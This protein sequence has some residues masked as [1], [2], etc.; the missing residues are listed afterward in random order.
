[1]NPTRLGAVTFAVPLG[2]LIGLAAACA[3]HHCLDGQSPE[4]S[5]GGTLADQSAGDSAVSP[6][7]SAECGTRSMARPK[8]PTQGINTVPIRFAAKTESASFTQPQPIDSP[9][10]PAAAELKGP[11]VA[12]G[13][14]NRPTLAPPLRPRPRSSGQVIEIRVDAEQIP[15]EPA[16]QKR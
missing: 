8:C 11:P 6:R 9:R 1:M 13:G 7:R 14:K 10:H 3:A 2:V 12:A 15:L 4:P 5:A 16:R